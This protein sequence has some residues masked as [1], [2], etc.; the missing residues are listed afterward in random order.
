MGKKSREKRER[1]ERADARNAATSPLKQMQEFR[2]RSD[3]QEE[4]DLH[5]QRDVVAVE[6]VLRKYVRSD[7]AIA[8]TVSDL[9]PPNV[10][11]PVKHLFVWAVLLGLQSDSNDA[12]SIQTHE[13]FA[14]FLTELYA[15]WP[16]FPMLEDCPI[17]ADWGRVR[18]PLGDSYV[19]IFYGSCVERLPDFVQ[20]FRITHAGNEAALADMDFAVALHADLIGAVPSP[21]G[22]A[23]LPESANGHVEVPPEDFWASC[24]AA[25]LSTGARVARWRANASAKLVAPMGAY[26]APLTWDSFGDAVLA[27]GALPFLGVAQGETWFPV[28]LRN[29]PGVIIDHWAEAGAPGITAQT[30]KAV[31]RYV[32]DRLQHVVIGP[33]KLM[34]SRQEFPALTVSCTAT[35]GSKVHLFCTCDHRSLEAAGA[36][37][38]AVYSALRSGGVLNLLLDDGRGLAFGRGEHSDPGAGDVQIV[39]VLT[40][41]GT[42]FNM[43]DAPK[44][45]TRIIPLADLVSIFDGLEDMWELEQFWSFADTQREI[46]S[47]FSCAIADLFGTFKDTHGV[48]VEGAINPTMITLDP[49]WGSG[50]RFRNLTEFWASAPPRFPD[51]SPGWYVQRTAKGVVELR[52][53][54]HAAMAYSTQVGSCTVQATVTMEPGL[55]VDDA[56]MADMFAQ[57]VIG[58]LHECAGDFQSE[59]LFQRQQLVFDCCLADHGRVEREQSPARL[60]CFEKIVLSAAGSLGNPARVELKLHAIAIQAGLNGARDAAFEARCL[61]EAF[62]ACTASLGITAP[63]NL[64]TRLAGLAARPARYH[65]QVLERTIDVPD[66]ADPIVPT[67]T[68]YKLA[69]KA[70]AVVMKESGLEPGRYELHEAKVRIDAARERFRLHLEKQLA[71]LEREMLTIACVEQHDGLLLARRIRETRVHQSRVH[72]VDYDRMEALSEARKEFETTARNYRYLL[73]KT[74]NAT[75]SGQERITPQLLRELIGLVDWY[76][77]LAGA[78]DVLHNQVDVSGVEINDQF[79]PEVFYSDTWQEREEEYAHELAKIRLGEGIKN[80]DA[81]EGA[82][83]EL[84]VSENL[85]KA[86]QA[87]VGFDLQ[88]LLQ[89]LTVFTQPVRHGLANDLALF[90]L[91]EPDHLA[92]A[93]V[94]GF[95]GITPAE[96]SAI[97]SFLMLSGPDIRRLPGK[98][99]DESDVPFWEHSKRLHRYA[100]RPLVPVGKQVVWGAESA[101]RSQLIWLSAV[102]DGVLPADFQWPNV[103][104]V[105]RSI[106]KLIEDALEDRAVEILKRHTPYVEGGVDFFRRFRKEGFADVG[107]YDVLAYWPAANTVLY[108]ECKYNQTAHSMK[109]SRRL[110]DR[111][112]GVSDMD[113]DGQYSRIRGRRE[114]LAEN[115]ARMFDLLKW[116]KP[117]QVPPRDVEVYVSRE[118]HYWMVSPPYEVPTKF[119]RVD[120]LDAWVNNGMRTEKH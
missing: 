108:A 110:R 4:V 12:Q 96:A 91:G 28:S 111:M 39:I 71:P 31:G 79:V 27:G 86:F 67:P 117:A 59:A 40:Q 34:V 36:A 32:A 55:K 62:S 69:R 19:P 22:A 44:R 112:F 49:H 60:E 26:K 83:A 16:E 80:A 109:D 95:E 24:R 98:E 87:D 89:A 78:S 101:S 23:V 115:R 46:L 82:M 42:S 33:M 7:A 47:P 90:Y 105:V 14:N 5:F 6:A 17:E 21:A 57:M 92:H 11:S 94:Q 64:A 52:S 53:R 41:S 29:G 13:D 113:R 68:E 25:L 63:Q 97:V 54:H 88:K 74:V 107:D 102:R 58:A 43:F 48:L 119:I 38:S 114:F 10:A 99:I 100:I 2:G 81:V 72:Q 1:R 45:P 75:T 65:L 84:L 9:W 116:P 18:A 85:Q 37:S 56:K 66:F 3:Q 70:L 61:Q 20:A 93:I 77:V 8:V 50:W 30:H 35:G 120:A 76:M 118:L 73:E 103:Q 104:A 106:K 15:A 51:G